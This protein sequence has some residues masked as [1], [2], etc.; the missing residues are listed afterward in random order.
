ML[1]Q[2]LGHMACYCPCI[3]C[4]DCHDYGHVTADWP[5]KSHHQAYQQDTEIPTLTED[6]MIDPHLRITIEIGTI[7][8]TIKT[9]I[10]L[11]G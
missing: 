2:E 11:A 1:C 7:I 9:G 3:R 4:F 6:D 5:D 8:M 10:G